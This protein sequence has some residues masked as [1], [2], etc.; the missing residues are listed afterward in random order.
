M[1]TGSC[2]PNDHVSLTLRCSNGDPMSWFRNWFGKSSRS[3]APR[4]SA[5][6]RPFGKPRLG[7]E[8]LE[9]RE[10][11]SGGLLPGYYVGSNNFVYR[12]TSSGPQVVYSGSQS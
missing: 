1:R 2:S 11:M 3:K 7:V 4:G 5:A 12:T 8:A 10:V 6:P 9:I